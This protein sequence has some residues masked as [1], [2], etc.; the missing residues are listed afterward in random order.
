MN[1]SF[2]LYIQS[3]TTQP[4]IGQHILAHQTDNDIVV[5]QAYK[6]VI[7]KFALENKILGGSDFRY[8]RMSW[9]KPNFLWMM[10]QCG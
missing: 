7:A 10:Y 1:L 6:P 3:L 5:H 2:N 8:N 9:I 4:Q